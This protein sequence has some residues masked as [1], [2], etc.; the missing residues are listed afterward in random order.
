MLYFFDNVPYLVARRARPDRFNELNLIVCRC[1]FRADCG[2]CWTSSVRGGLRVEAQR[3]AWCD[4]VFVVALSTWCSTSVGGTVLY[5]VSTWWTCCRR[6]VVHRLVF[7][8]LWRSRFGGV[9][10]LYACSGSSCALSVRAVENK[11][12]ADDYCVENTLAQERRA[13]SVLIVI[14]V[15][16]C[17]AGKCILFCGSHCGDYFL[18]KVEAKIKAGGAYRLENSLLPPF[19]VVELRSRTSPCSAVQRSACERRSSNSWGLRAEWG[20][21]CSLGGRVRRTSSP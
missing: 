17:V 15:V 3:S 7:F 18:L 1:A 9:L 21:M 19:R 6:V 11:E 8:F 10:W 5:D 16:P 14:V 12:Y 13:L 20:N 4:Y 2:V